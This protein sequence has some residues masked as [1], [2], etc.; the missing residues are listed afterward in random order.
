MTRDESRILD[1]RSTGRRK[2]RR[3]LYS[4]Y[5]PYECVG[6]DEIPCG[7][8]SK[9]P[10]KDAPKHFEELWPAENRVLDYQLQADHEDK[11]VTNNDISNLNWRCAFHHKMS[12]KR[13]G[14]GESTI[15]VEFF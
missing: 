8:T 12:D 2:A 7:K 10:P 11:D 3:A 4:S 6:L 13:T 9:E 15:H 1:W 14:V 5:I